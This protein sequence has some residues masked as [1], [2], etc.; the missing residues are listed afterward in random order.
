MFLNRVILLVLAI[1]GTLANF[2][3][4]AKFKTTIF[5][6]YVYGACDNQPENVLNINTA[7]DT[8]EF[9]IKNDVDNVTL[10]GNLTSRWNIQ[11]TDRL[12]GIFQLHYLD[13]G[14]W[15]PTMYSIRIKNVCA[16]M[17]DKNQHWYKAWT[18]HIINIDDVKDNCVNVPG[19][20]L[21]HEPFELVFIFDLRTQ[22]DTNGLYRLFI[23]ISAYDELSRKRDTSICF[24]I[25]VQFERID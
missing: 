22:I 21:I 13:H 18:S 2:S 6:D 9:I 23:A 16:V 11:K 7:F 5:D 4:T 12:E 19:A 25:R 17:F 15:Q 10:S 14:S 24:T 1:I 8:S 20:K 3:S